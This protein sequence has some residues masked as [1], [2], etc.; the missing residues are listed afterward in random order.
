MND[1]VANQAVQRINRSGAGECRWFLD[2][3]SVSYGLSCAQCR[4]YYKARLAV[5]SICEYR[6][7]VSAPIRTD[8]SGCVLAGAKYFL[9]VGQSTAGILDQWADASDEHP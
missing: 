3:P 7:R 5:C 8:E 2:R 1:Y 6:D 4:A 9:E